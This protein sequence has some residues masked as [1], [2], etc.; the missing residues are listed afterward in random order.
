MREDRVTY[1]KLNVNTMREDRLT[2]IK[3]NVNSM[4]LRYDTQG[5][6]NILGEI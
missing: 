6:K 1:I 5:P 4:R 3:L 2:Y